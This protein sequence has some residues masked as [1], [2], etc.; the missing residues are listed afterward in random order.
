MVHMLLWGRYLELDIDFPSSATNLILEYMQDGCQQ[1]MTPLI[2]ISSATV[3]AY[4]D[5]AT[6]DS[7]ML[8]LHML[9]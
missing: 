1:H 9:V 2:K 5:A 8:M 6:Y 7:S 3:V 4:N